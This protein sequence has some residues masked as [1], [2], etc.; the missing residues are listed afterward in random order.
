[1]T[2]LSS[3]TVIEWG[4]ATAVRQ[5]G[6]LLGSLGA[7]VTR[8]A[9]GGAQDPNGIADAH[10]DR[11][12]EVV[13]APREA[14]ERLRLL[15]RA[16][17]LITDGTCPVPFDEVLAGGTDIVAI[18]AFGLTGPDAGAPGGDLIASHAG[19]YAHYVTWSVDDPAVSPPTRGPAGQAQLVAGLTGAVAAASRLVARVRGGVPELID[20]SEQEAVA[21]LL[22]P[23]LSEHTEGTLKTGRHRA[24]GGSKV[25]GGLVGL[26]RC[27]D[28]WVIVSPREDHQWARMM[29]ILGDPP[30]GSDAAAATAALRMA[31]WEDLQRRLSAWSTGYPKEKIFRDFQAARIPCFPVNRVADALALP[32]LAVREFF[33]TTADGLTGPGTPWTGRAQP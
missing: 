17:L 24:R 1:M 9:L 11:F 6:T 3:A 26:L 21:T 8:L 33:Y 10:L 12:T 31:N 23:Q 29:S 25:A 7:Q 19:G 28:G 30:W 32:Q 16:D 4:T 18:T 20:V 13:A 2:A 22:L 14:A 27:A 15:A 5:C